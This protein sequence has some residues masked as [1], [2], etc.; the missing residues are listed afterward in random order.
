M[1]RRQSLWLLEQTIQHLCVSVAKKW[2]KSINSTFLDPLSLMK[3]VALRHRLAMARTAM[4]QLS[5]IWADRSI[6]KTTKIRLVKAL[7][8]PIAT[9][10]CESWTMTSSNTDKINAFELWCWR[11]MLRINWTMKRT[12]RSVLR[13]VGSKMSLLAQINSQTLSYFGHIARRSGPCLEKVV[14]QG[15]IEGARKRGRPRMR[16]FDRIKTLVG[17]SSTTIYKLAADR[18]KWRVICKVTNC[19]SWQNRTS[20]PADPYYYYVKLL[21]IIWHLWYH[22]R[23]HLIIFTKIFM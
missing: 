13:E 12:N 2:K 7:V 6:T 23:Y 9:Y 18:Q 10:G 14:M 20:Q 21:Q 17:Q 4:T 5:K 16:W 11:R 8:F 1:F 19:Q 22:R 3:D 15:K